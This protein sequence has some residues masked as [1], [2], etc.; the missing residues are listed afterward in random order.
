M[1]FAITEIDS[2][3]AGS[4]HRTVDPASQI[5]ELVSA[6]HYHPQSELTMFLL[7]DAIRAERVLEAHIAEEQARCHP[8]LCYRPRRPCS[9]QDGWQVMRIFKPQVV[10]PAFDG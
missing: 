8:Q 9:S 4:G 5:G 2:R 6:L 10:A 3:G 7:E 1:S